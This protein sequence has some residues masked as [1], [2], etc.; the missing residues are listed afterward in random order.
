MTDRYNSFGRSDSDLQQ[1]VCISNTAPANL[2]VK[3][4]AMQW[5]EYILQTA[6][7]SR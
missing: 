7:V 6:Q 5:D 1:C 4:I 3:Y 2:A